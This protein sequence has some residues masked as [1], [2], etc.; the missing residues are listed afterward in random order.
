[1][2][3]SMKRFYET[4]KFSKTLKQWYRKLEKSGFE[5]AEYLDGNLQATSYFKT[6][7]NTLGRSSCEPT[8]KDDVL[9]YYQICSHWRHHMGHT[10]FNPMLTKKITLQLLHTIWDLH[11]D[12]LTYAKIYS[13]INKRKQVIGLKKLKAVIKQL[14]TEC[15]RWYKYSNFDDF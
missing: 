5:D 9:Q 12:G 2:Q 10:D 13:S 3:S 8:V 4:K 15:F 14:E 11:C 6:V 1:M 7:G